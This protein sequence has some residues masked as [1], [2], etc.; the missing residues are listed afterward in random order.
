MK[1][2]SAPGSRSDQLAEPQ[3]A[4]HYADILPFE[5]LAEAKTLLDK[6]MGAGT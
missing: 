2:I 3:P 6:E 1:A 4:E 5:T